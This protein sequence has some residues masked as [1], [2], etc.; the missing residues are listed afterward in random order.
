MTEPILFDTPAPA[1][2]ATWW[3]VNFGPDIETGED[4]IHG[5]FVTRAAAETALSHARA[6]YGMDG[7]IVTC[8]TTAWEEA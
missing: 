8:H 1:L 5:P 4:S 6:R 2:V 7:H 3:A